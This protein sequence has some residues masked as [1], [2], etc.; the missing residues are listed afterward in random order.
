MRSF[1]TDM[2]HGLRH[3]VKPGAPPRVAAGDDAALCGDAMPAAEPGALVGG[4]GARH[5]KRSRHRQ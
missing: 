2:K 4:V 5:R 1:W 3:W